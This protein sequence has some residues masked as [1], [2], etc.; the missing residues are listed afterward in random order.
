MKTTKILRWFS[1]FSFF[2]RHWLRASLLSDIPS[3]S[4]SKPSLQW[5]WHLQSYVSTCIRIF[6]N[7]Y[8]ANFPNV[9]LHSADISIF[10]N[11]YS[12]KF[13]IFATCI[14]HFFFTVEFQNR[15]LQHNLQTLSMLTGSP[16]DHCLSSDFSLDSSPSLAELIVAKSSPAVNKTLV[17]AQYSFFSDQNFLP[18]LREPARLPHS[19]KSLIFTTVFGGISWIFG[20]SRRFPQFPHF[21]RTSAQKK[22]L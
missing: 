17:C 22:K 2:S 13:P 14:A 9:D 8:S 11:L 4:V 18:P 19:P 7:L 20:A 15:I 16:V 21:Q 1:N 12:V 10:K 3:H 6:C 5:L